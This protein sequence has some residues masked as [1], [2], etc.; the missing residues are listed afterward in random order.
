MRFFWVCVAALALSSALAQG[1][2]CRGKKERW[3][4]TRI[5]LW[6]F[7]HYEVGEQYRKLDLFWPLFELEQS[8]GRSLL[9]LYPFVFRKADEERTHWGFLF[10]LRRPFVGLWGAETWSGHAEVWMLPFL[11]YERDF[12]ERYT[13]VDLFMWLFSYRKSPSRLTCWLFPVFHYSSSRYA[14]ESQPR[15]RLALFLWLAG[16]SKTQNSRSFWLIPLFH[17]YQWSDGY[18]T[19]VLPPLIWVWR[20]PQ[21]R[22]YAFFPFFMFHRKMRNGKTDAVRLFIFP[23]YYS[24]RRWTTRTGTTEHP[25]YRR[26]IS[27]P[28]LF[29]WLYV[30][31]SHIYVGVVPYVLFNY[32]NQFGYGTTRRIKIYALLYLFGIGVSKNEFVLR[33]VPIL[34]HRSRADGTGYTVLFP[35]LWHFT[36]T[37]ATMSIL[38]P[39]FWYYEERVAVALADGTTTTRVDFTTLIGLSGYGR[40]GSKHFFHI[41]FPI[42]KVVYDTATGD[43]S[44][45]LVPYA[46]QVVSS[47]V[48]TRL[49]IFPL[50]YERTDKWGHFVAFPLFWYHWCSGWKRIVA[51]PF[52]GYSWS[53]SG[54]WWSAWIAPPLLYLHRNIQKDSFCFDVLGVLAG[55][56]YSGVSS[57]RFGAEEV[58]GRRRYAFLVPLFWWESSPEETDFWLSVP[59][60]RYHRWRNP[61]GATTTDF[62]W[63]LPYCR[64]YCDENERVIHLLWE[65]VRWRHDLISGHRRFSVLWYILR[66]ESDAVTQKVEFNFLYRLVWYRATPKQVRFYIF[67]II[68]Y[69]A[70]D[71][72]PRY[73]V[74]RR[75]GILGGLF[76]GG[77]KAQ[78]SFL[79]LFFFD[80]NF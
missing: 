52:F 50:F 28:L 63:F 80:I 22:F 5:A 26:N 75:L 48:G 16:Y 33:I 40:R 71:E 24:R 51:V 68:S 8:D 35:L 57:Y 47:G 30:P 20:S 56:G 79:T 67:P 62:M 65:L 15:R 54:N 59:P 13:R 66:W 7:L 14:G 60:L 64:Y 72:H 10:L 9:S 19:T 49:N 21:T 41:L 44:A 2:S 36:R 61:T 32:Y 6:P 70:S 37:D 4:Q 29:Q 38:F 18:H 34:W 78:R 77:R 23:V 46:V 12:Q 53:R 3:R 45:T 1:E 43:W 76:G 42:S 31:N 69:T 17:H 73:G 74:Y 25:L 27:V 55:Y 11:S 58:S 39:V